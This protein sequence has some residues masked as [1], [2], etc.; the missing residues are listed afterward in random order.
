MEVLQAAA[1]VVLHSLALL[2]QVTA[3]FVQELLRH[4]DQVNRTEE[5]QE[6]TL[7]DAANPCST[8]QGAAGSRLAFALLE[9]GDTQTLLRP[10]KSQW[11]VK[12][13]CQVLYGK[14]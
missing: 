14:L 3:C 8:V 11:T 7:G 9:T 13:K 6:K 12:Y 4:V 10:Q 1:E 2:T 5:W